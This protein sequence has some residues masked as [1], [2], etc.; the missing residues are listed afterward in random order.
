M[1]KFLLL[2]VSCFAALFS[3]A[4]C[5]ITPN[6]STFIM[7]P[8]TVGYNYTLQGTLNYPASRAFYICQGTVLT[9][10]NRTGND[11][12]YIATGAK[13]IG[14]EAG[15]FRV[16]LKTSATY[17]ATGGSTATIYYE[18]GSNIVN[19]TGP[20]LPPCPSLTISLSVIGPNVC[21]TTTGIAEHSNLKG[22]IFVFP[23]PTQNEIAINSFV[24]ATNLT[25]IVY[26]MIGNIVL[27]HMAVS[28]Q[29]KLDISPLSKGIY[30]LH[31]LNGNEIVGT[32]KFIK[33]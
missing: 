9:I 30:F 15:P 4:Q 7:S 22:N 6:A 19:F 25:L 24:T 20:L 13:L 1:K 12:F 33:N 8:L 23:N 10:Q 2:S 3:I 21:T 11:T 18:T 17:D 27:Q 31:V 14:T 26:D 29:A 28:N 5:S 32:E 16:F